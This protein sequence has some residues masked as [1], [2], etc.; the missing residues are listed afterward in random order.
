MAC[1]D[2][3]PACAQPGCMLCRW[4]P[5]GLVVLQ[6]ACVADTADLES[7]GALDVAP[8]EIAFGTLGSECG[9]FE[10]PVVISNQGDA[11]VEVR[12]IR[13]VEGQAFSIISLPDPLPEDVLE[14]TPRATVS[15]QVR[16]ETRIEGEHRDVLEV[17]GELAGEPFRETV[18]LSGRY[19]PSGIRIDSHT[20]SEQ[21]DADILFVLDNS[22]SMVAEQDSLTRNFQSFID[23]ANSGLLDYQIGVTNTDVSVGDDSA[24]GRL[25]PLNAP[26]EERIVTRASSPYP[27]ARFVANAQGVAPASGSGDERG[28][29]A[30]RLAL[31]PENLEEHNFGLIRD[32]ALLSVIIISDEFDQSLIT[33]L[34]VYEETLLAVKGGDRSK[35]TVS[36]VVGPEPMGCTG[37]GG[38]ATEAPRYSELARRMGGV[39]E[40]ICTSNWQEV[41]TRLSSTAFGLRARF[42][43]VE[44][45]EDPEAIVV[46]VDG[47]EIPRLGERQAR[48]RY[49]T[50]SNSVVFVSQ[51]IPGPGAQV[52]LEYRTGCDGR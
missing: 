2:Q 15:V 30:M 14:L 34:D 3:I 49:Q 19:V 52:E 1:L 46:R 8:A 22:C 4:A 33:D 5:L 39:I 10:Q 13:L 41:L 18:A 47:T 48:W 44:R 45:P 23:I 35:V 28:L 25:L 11:K 50:A 37:P 12:Q 27:S 36:A 32:H 9:P 20:Q 21:A 24:R 42:S 31:S 17:I 43:L 6:A 38:P 51:H 29:E 16:F 7:L 26:R 40:S